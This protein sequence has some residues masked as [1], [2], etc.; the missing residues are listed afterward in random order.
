MQIKQLRACVT[1]HF[2]RQ[3]TEKNRYFI[4]I[5]IRK[6]NKIANITRDLVDLRSYVGNSLDYHAL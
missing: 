3:K 6:T 2:I 1:H 4:I 5:I